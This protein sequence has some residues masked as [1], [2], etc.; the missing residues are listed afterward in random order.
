MSKKQQPRRPRFDGLSIEIDESHINPETGKIELNLH[1]DTINHEQKDFLAHNGQE[2]ESK[3]QVHGYFGENKMRTVWE[4]P[5]DKSD[6][7]LNYLKKILRYEKLIVM[8]T[9]SKIIKNEMFSV[10][11]A[12]HLVAK[13]NEN[14]IDWEF[15]PINQIFTIV[16]KGEKIENRN[17]KSLIEYILQH[18]VYKPEHKLGIIVDSDLGEI[19][20]YNSKQKPIF[21][22]FYLPDNFELIFASDKTSDNPLSQAI[23]NCHDLSTK[24]LKIIE[25]EIAQASR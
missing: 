15:I 25:N 10:G 9:N 13:K 20:N 21:S 6:N 19:D 2:L 5:K 8:D 1:F 18:P 11:I 12:A 24:T 22:E 4:I 16:G 14:N 17:W 3:K 7:S 23:K